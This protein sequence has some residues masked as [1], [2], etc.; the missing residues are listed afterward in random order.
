MNKLSCYIYLTI[1]STD[2][3]NNKKYVLSTKKEEL[4]L[5][6]FELN[7][8]NILNIDNFIFEYLKNILVVNPLE[9]RPS[10]LSINS[11]SLPASIKK[12]NE[13]NIVYGSVIPLTQNLHN[14]YW[15]E[16]DFFL[17]HPYSNLLFE[18]VHSLT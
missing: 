14:S 15:Q 17:P 12:E 7:H 13:L 4:N 16:F 6:G 8:D 2:M 11:K 5:P 9:L 18:V 10:L 3:P 1:L